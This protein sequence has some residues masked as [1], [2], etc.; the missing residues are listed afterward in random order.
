MTVGPCLHLSAAIYVYISL[1]EQYRLSGTHEDVDRVRSYLLRRAKYLES[2]VVVM[3][4]DLNRPAHLQP[5]RRNIVRVPSQLRTSQLTNLP[6]L[7]E[8][9]HLV[10]NAQPEDS[11]FLYFSGHGMLYP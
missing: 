6:K 3:L 1:E 9:S 7:R 4:D 8:I 2:N 11:F 5:S 10:H